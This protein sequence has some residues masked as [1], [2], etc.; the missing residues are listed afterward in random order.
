MA[1]YSR[2]ATGSVTSNG[3][4]TLVILPFTPNFIEIFNRGR[5]VAQNG[6][7]TTTFCITK[8]WWYTDMG[9]TAAGYT[10][11][12]TAGDYTGW[13]APTGGT[14][15]SIPTVVSGTG[16]TTI[17]AALALQYGP[18]FNNTSNAFSIS[19]ANPAVVT[20]STAHNLTTGNWVIFQNLSQS[21]TT[22]MQQIA[23][24]PFMITVT[25]ATTFTIPWN[26]NQS[27]YTAFNTATSTGNVGSF[28]QILYPVL[29]APGVSFISA[30]TTG[31]TT[32]VVTTA[33]HNFVQGQ[34]IAFRIPQAYGT[35]QL[36]SLPN[37]VIPGSP[38]YGYVTS[39]TNSTTFVCNINSTGYTA[40]A[41]NQAFANYPG[42][43][44]PQVLAV[45][46]VNTG[47]YLYNGGM[48]YP[49]PSVFNGYVSSTTVGASTIN[50]PAIQ[51]AYY[52][53]TFQGF[54]IGT[55]IS[56][57]STDVIDYRAILSD[58]NS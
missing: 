33:P 4:Q 2:I 31:T 34:E 55:G 1:E 37:L 44:F 29:Y 42:Q 11:T 23:G 19:K 7:T 35:T 57:T 50:G 36:N 25:G 15:S 17:Q 27:N 38:I 10:Q 54:I 24:I 39:V 14:S 3:G 43:T 48:L 20:T 13:I 51:G 45:G 41:T 49:S 30:I 58:I 16:F 56:G 47:G 40:F 12:T 22:G 46:D 6:N 26:T 52:N 53:A 9:Q 18:V 28:K 21:A 32:T 5:A 8:A